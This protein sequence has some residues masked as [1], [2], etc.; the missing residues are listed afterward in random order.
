MYR[1]DDY[2]HHHHQLNLTPNTTVTATH[3]SCIFS[4]LVQDVRCR[5]KSHCS[6]LYARSDYIPM[7]ARPTTIII[8]TTISIT[9]PTAPPFTTTTTTTITRPSPT[10]PHHYFIYKVWGKSGSQRQQYR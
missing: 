3:D 10:S 9:T 1:Y 5:R 8:K 2:L 7:T 6:Y 4:R